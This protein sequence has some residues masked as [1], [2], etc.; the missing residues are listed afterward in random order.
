MQKCILVAF[1]PKNCSEITTG[2]Y[3]CTEKGGAG[4]GTSEKGANPGN[5]GGASGGGGASEG[6]IERRGSK[7][8]AKRRLRPPPQ[9]RLRIRPRANGRVPPSA[10]SESRFLAAG[11]V[12][13]AS[14]GA[15]T[16]RA[17]LTR[18]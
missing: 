6:N 9:A 12:T 5:G 17:V 18:C 1:Y 3:R 16:S 4:E 2:T 7:S 8:A 13:R 11:P 14:A 15:G 10:F